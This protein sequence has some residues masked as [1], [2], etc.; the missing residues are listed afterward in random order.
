[1]YRH[2]RGA[3]CYLASTLCAMC[4]P[5]T[6]IT[7]TRRLL[8]L[9]VAANVVHDRLAT[10]NCSA[11]KSMG[12]LTLTGRC[13]GLL[14]RHGHTCRFAQCE[15]AHDAC[16]VDGAEGETRWSFLPPLIPVPKVGLGGVVVLACVG[17]PP[18][19][20]AGISAIIPS[21][22]HA[23]TWAWGRMQ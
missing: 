13:E 22:G 4:H 8:G 6:A 12:D 10:L 17:S 16:A 19:L 11:V 15:S 7:C 21:Y 20:A 14:N 1:M 5:G 18:A 23:R 3:N 9:R 2:V